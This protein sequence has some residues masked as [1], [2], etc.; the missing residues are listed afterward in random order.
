MTSH[1]RHRR[2]DSAAATF[3]VAEP[4]EL[5]LNV[6]NLQLAI[7]NV[8]TGEPMTLL[9]IR[10]YSDRSKYA[11][12]ELMAKDGVI[13]RAKAAINPGA[14]DPA[15]WDPITSGPDYVAKAGDTM[16]GPLTLADDPT[17]PLHAATKQYADSKDVD[18][19]PYVQKAGSAMTGPL[20]LPGMPTA[21]LQ[22]ATKKYVDDTVASGGVPI[23]LSLYVE[24]TGSTMTGALV[25]AGAPT[26]DL[27]AVPKAYVDA[28]VDAVPIADV[29]KD[30]V[31][32]QDALA[33]NMAGG[34]TITGGFRF[35]PFNAGTLGAAQTFT[36]N[37]YN[38]NYQYYANN[39]AHTF[40]TPANDCALDVLITNTALA[41]VINFSG[42]A[43]G[44]LPGDVLTVT[45]GHRF[46]VSIRRI[47]GVS[48]YSVKALQ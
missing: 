44:A 20:V 41:G 28:A 24:K 36:P 16:T 11:V 37:A 1:V 17:Q 6:P 39:G 46:I 33:M 8:I 42:Y 5:M 7:G 35:T 23:D 38:G 40:A 29:D 32:T 34:Q 19:E 18:L 21:D 27:E 12:A 15:Q 3:P 22:A 48:T 47:N 43:V 30:Y 4:G 10:I 26:A 31:D 45:N 2:F 13:Y 9:A 25:L 14:F